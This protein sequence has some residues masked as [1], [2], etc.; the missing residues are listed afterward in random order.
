MIYK[1]EKLIEIERIRY[2]TVVEKQFPEILIIGGVDVFGEFNTIKCFDIESGNYKIL[3]KHIVENPLLKRKDHSCLKNNHLI[4]VLGG[5][6]NF[7]NS[8]CIINVEDWTIK[9]ITV[10][11]NM[12][13]Y[14]N[15]YSSLRKEFYLFSGKYIYTLDSKFTISAVT[16][17]S[18][19]V[20]P[21]KNKFKSILFEGWLYIFGGFN[22]ISFTKKFFRY[23]I[24]SKKK[25]HLPSLP[26]SYN[27][28]ISGFEIL[29][30]DKKIYFILNMFSISKNNFL[31]IY[32]LEFQ[33]WENYYILSFD[34]KCQI[35]DIYSQDKLLLGMKTCMKS[36][37]SFVHGNEM[38]IFGSD[39]LFFDY[40]N[41]IYK[42][43]TSFCDIPYPN[44]MLST[45]K[46]K[47]FRIVSKEHKY[48]E[49]NKFLLSKFSKYFLNMFDSVFD[50]NFSEVTIDFSYDI[51]VFVK[52]Y[53][54][55][56]P[57]VD[58]SYIPGGQMLD[59]IILADYLRMETLLHDLETQLILYPKFFKVNE[60]KSFLEKINLPRLERMGFFKK[61]KN[62]KICV[63]VKK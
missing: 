55:S 16:P 1:I 23:N 36:Y 47:D 54:Y 2:F 19:Y 15:A 32:N 25:E 56:F 8:I 50:E 61:K 21:S 3:P 26:N 7:Q 30:M 17:M 53:M 20:A 27:I 48:I 31:Y 10:D 49:C 5:N 60:M 37:G 44:D 62:E 18:M 34:N 24:V 51:L 28:R 29:L 45:Q 11:L 13:N 33:K 57:D 42:I 63:F 9:E 58:F 12:K 43:S 59:L 6:D 22:G 52:K 40:P 38:Y 41:A 46:C 39:A 4:Y 35:V 14:C